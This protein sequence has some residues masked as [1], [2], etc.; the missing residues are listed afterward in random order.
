MYNVD[1][2]SSFAGTIETELRH[3]FDPT[4]PVIKRDENICSPGRCS[5]EYSGN[6]EMFMVSN[7]K[8]SQW[9]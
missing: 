2:H 9:S 5:L 4:I 1:N 3:I 6:T 8:I 7:W